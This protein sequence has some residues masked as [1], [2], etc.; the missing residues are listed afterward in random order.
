MEYIKRNR[1]DKISAKISEEIVK[2]D[3]ELIRAC[4]QCGTCTGSC[5]SGRRTA[6]RTRAVIRKALLGLDQVLDDPD[7]WLCSTC[8]TCFERC[9]RQVPV[10]DIII[11]LRN[12]A[13]QKGR[14]LAPHKSLT[15]LLIDTG[16]GVPINDKKWNDLR[17]SYDLDPVPPTV[18]KYPSAVKEVQTLV[19]S[20]GF[21]KLVEYKP[22]VN[23][24]SKKD[25]KPE[26]KEEKATR[27][28][29]KSK[30]KK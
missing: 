20:L 27:K 23:T 6:L 10:T 8:Y 13:T 19:K 3:L 14:I 22:P 7:I 2:D 28:G 4:Y 25:E 26:K 18:H 17:E 5:P 9:P 15:H 29:R 21:D 30:I 1:I 16:H 24:N 12:L 11:K